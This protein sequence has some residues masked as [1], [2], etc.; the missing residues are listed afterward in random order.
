MGQQLINISLAP[1]RSCISPNAGNSKKCSPYV[2]AKC[3]NKSCPPVMQ[4]SCGN[5]EDTD[6]LPVG[7][8]DSFQ[9]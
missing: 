7:I 3:E 6:S 2:I 1:Y 8:V 4:D 5:A 9:S